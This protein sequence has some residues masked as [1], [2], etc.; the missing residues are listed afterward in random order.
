MQSNESQGQRHPQGD[1]AKIAAQIDEVTVGRPEKKA[2][3]CTH[4]QKVIH[5]A[6]NYGQYLRGEWQKAKD[7]GWTQYDENKREPEWFLWSCPSWWSCHGF[8]FSDDEWLQVY[9]YIK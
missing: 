2:K 1:L 3:F 5:E 7:A 9:F 4:I 8:Y 6:E